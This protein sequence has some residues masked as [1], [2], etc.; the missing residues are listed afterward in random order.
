MFVGW[1][2]TAGIVLN[3][4]Y[5]SGRHARITTVVPRRCRKGILQAEKFP[6][7]IFR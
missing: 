3:N 5:A 6:A 4:D 7:G 2:D 1:G